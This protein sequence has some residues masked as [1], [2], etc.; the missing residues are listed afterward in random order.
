MLNAIKVS[1]TDPP[2]IRF[3]KY[4]NFPNFGHG[5]QVLKVWTYI[6]TITKYT[7]IYLQYTYTRIFRY[8]R[9]HNIFGK[10]K[11]IMVLIR[12]PVT[13]ELFLSEYLILND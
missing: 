13:S 10:I 2:T 9:N 7:Y 1:Q 12:I 4:E 5:F 11:I 3:H 6:G 8:D